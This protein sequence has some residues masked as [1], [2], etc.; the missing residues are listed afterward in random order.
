MSEVRN[1]IINEPSQMMIYVDANPFVETID[2]LD[3]YHMCFSDDNVIKT[4]N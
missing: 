2:L 3:R 4:V 1:F